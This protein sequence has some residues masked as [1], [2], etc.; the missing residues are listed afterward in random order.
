MSRTKKS[1]RN[2]AYNIFNVTLT[3]V[4]MF[5]VRTVFIQ[6]L[7]VSYLGLNGV[8]QNI[9]QFLALAELGIG[10]AISYRL[11][12]PLNEDN[13][14]RIA[15]LMQFFKKAY[16]TISALIVVISLALLPFLNN[17]I[18]GDIPDVNL[19][20]VYF[21]Y[22]SQ[23]LS[24]YLFFAYKMTLLKADQREYII[25]KYGNYVV[26][27]SSL[28]E[29][30]ILYFFQS[31]IGYLLVV[32]FSNIIKNLLV[33]RRVDK[34]Y[35]YLN[36][37]DDKLDKEE[38]KE[39]FKDF[40]AAFLYRINNVVVNSTDNLVLSYFVGLN[41]VG[42]Y[43]NYVLI[44]RNL[45]NFLSPS[46]TSLK[47]SLGSFIAEKSKEESY[48]IFQMINIL[49]II[50]YGGSS[51]GIFILSNR[52]IRLWIGTEFTLSLMFVLL[53]SFDFYFRG[54]TSFLAQIRNS[55]GLFQQIKYRP[56]ASMVSN[57]ILSIILV[58]FYGI[59]GVILATIISMVFTNMLFDPL[60]IHTFG[61]N[62]KATKYFLKNAYYILL[63]S[64]TGGVA[65]FLSSFIP[66]TFIGLF[67]TFIMTSLV[68]VIVFGAG[69]FWIKEFR[70]LVKRVVSFIKT[71]N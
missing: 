64:L 6:T 8:F 62:I 37:Y 42:Y 46:L 25:S 24:T 65:Y 17:L 15:A 33:S 29:L 41:I 22:I 26:V 13:K 7:G 45:K 14:R 54:M 56:I 60:V 5:G 1:V 30:A 11:Y 9:F 43:S 2:I 19:Y 66:D 21:I 23:T 48:Q 3:L 31:F 36:E 59:E 12:K 47:A 51:I 32:V 27:V 68:I 35:P 50:M 70:L 67:L 10:S 57:L 40:F 38:L 18:G 20:V 61:F 4:M 55:M 39:M 52:F 69:L 28:T 63:M 58:Q 49:T 44:T 71:R 34:D 16:L 53:L